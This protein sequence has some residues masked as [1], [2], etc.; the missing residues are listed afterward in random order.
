MKLRATITT[1]LEV[2]N[3]PEAAEAYNKFMEHLNELEKKTGYKFELDM[4]ETRE[5]IRRKRGE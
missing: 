1:T 2:A 3:I 4:R 5:V